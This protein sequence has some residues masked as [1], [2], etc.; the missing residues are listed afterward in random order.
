MTIPTGKAAYS[1]IKELADAAERRYDGLKIDVLAMEN[2]FF[3]EL[4]TVTGLLTG[5]DI[6]AQLKERDNGDAVLICESTLRYEHDKVID[7]TTP[8]YVERELK[9]PVLMV[10]NDGYKLLCAMLGEK[11]DDE[12]EVIYG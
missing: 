11:A 8:D 1:T 10:P 4:I 3:G 5:G 7:D 2:N 9:L 6:A 12:C